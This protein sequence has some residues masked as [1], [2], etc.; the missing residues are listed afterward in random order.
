[1]SASTCIFCLLFCRTGGIIPAVAQDLHRN[2]IH[3][4]VETALKDA[5]V[6]V[7]VCI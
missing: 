6:H 4:V 7:Q 1:M 3:Q 5:S 2:S